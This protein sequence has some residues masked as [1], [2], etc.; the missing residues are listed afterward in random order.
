MADFADILKRLRECYGRPKPPRVTRPLEMILFEMVAYLCD[1][2]HRAATFAALKKRIGT[3][4][5]QLLS[6]DEETLVEICRMGGIQP[7][8]RARRI[9]MVAELALCD[10]GGDLRSVLKK[11]LKEAK[12][13]LMKF[14]SV[15]EPGAEKILLFNRC[16]PVLALD[17]NGLRVLQ[18]LGFA[19]ALKNYSTAYRA[20]REALQDQLPKSCDKLIEAHQLLRQHG[21]EICKTSRPLCDSCPFAPD[22]HYFQSNR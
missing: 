4:P 15:G 1:D 6:A 11:P 20:A 2:A 12:K 19:P 21:K 9:R 17:S 13:D 5:Q 22:C 3:K 14:P 10:F 16:H 8:H 7:E 18:R